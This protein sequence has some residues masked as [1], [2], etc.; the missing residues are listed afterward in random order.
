MADPRFF[1]NAGPYALGDIAQ[2]VGVDLGDGADASQMIQDIAPLDSAGPTD[3]SFLDN[4]KY[5][6]AF[7]ASSAGACIIHERHVERAPDHV[8][9]LIAKDPYRSYALASQLFY[10]QEIRGTSVFDASASIH[11]GAF[12]HPG[13]RVGQE[14]T[15]EPGA[16]LADGVEIGDGTTISTGV[17]VG[18]GCTVGRNCFIAPN[19][20]L[21][22]IHI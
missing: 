14:V 15:I 12:I 3:L 8:A 10:P 5:I 13:A 21:S 19:V 16:C 7:E 9:L 18:R 22:L 20:T 4:P 2:R 6:A 11:P 17:S 1:L